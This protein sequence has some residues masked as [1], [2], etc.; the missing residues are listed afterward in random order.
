MTCAAHSRISCSH[1]ARS[2]Q[3]HT[4]ARR[5]HGW[6]LYQRRQPVRAKNQRAE[7]TAITDPFNGM[8]K[9]LGR[10]KSKAT[11]RKRKKYESQHTPVRTCKCDTAERLVDIVLLVGAVAGGLVLAGWVILAELGKRVGLRPLQERV[12]SC[13]RDR[14]SVH[15]QCTGCGLRGAVSMPRATTCIR[16][17]HA[18]QYRWE[19]RWQVSQR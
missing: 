9:T 13:L 6:P 2:C 7:K 17:K 10:S 11:Q 19:L 3:H 8:A 5:S 1:T 18:S 4:M 12:L 16:E 15:G 14:C